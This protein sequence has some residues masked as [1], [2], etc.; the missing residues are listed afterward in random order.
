MR[1]RPGWTWLAFAGLLSTACAEAPERRSEGAAELPTM[2][3]QTVAAARAVEG[4]AAQVPAVVA[5][6]L[7]AAL[8]ARI[9]ASVVELPRRVGET[10]AAGEVMVRLDDAALRS[11]AHA[12]ETAREA[13]QT[14]LARIE[15]LHEKGAA[16][17]REAAQTDLAR[18]ER[19]HEKGAA[20]SRE[21]D[22]ARSQAAL[23]EAGVEA[24]RD[25][26]SYAVL[27][28]PFAGRVAARPANV[29]DVVS[30]GTTLIEI[31]GTGG[32]ELR[33]SID[34]TLARSVSAGTRLESR[35]DGL[36]EV[37]HATVRTIAPAAD[38][39]THR[40]ELKADLPRRAGIRAGLFARLSVP[41]AEGP[42]RILVPASAVFERG[43]LTGVFVVSDGR[44][45]LR[46]VAVGDRSRSDIEIRAGIEVAERVVVDPTGLVDDQP[47]EEIG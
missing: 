16:T 1:T 19:L 27:K 12:A 43:G 40:L 36:D 13:A 41:G 2:R 39:S 22:Q 45:L 17:S 7:Q 5:S 14:D 44:A 38:P 21:L 4:A 15:R 24:A 46:W 25:S 32:L 6:R 23:A 33:A 10:V 3:V 30:P 20:T 29:G 18:I 34:A 35:V 42:E 47:V 9:P 11:A 31:E 8:A 26:L 37:L 28:A